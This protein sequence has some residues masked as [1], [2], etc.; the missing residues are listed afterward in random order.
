MEGS[1]NEPG[2]IRQE[3][4]DTASGTADTKTNQTQRHRRIYG[5]IIVICAAGAG[6]EGNNYYRIS[7]LHL[8]PQD[9][10]YML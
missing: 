9:R 3:R 2:I 7:R 1:G 5:F 10:E 8:Y 6:K 4:T